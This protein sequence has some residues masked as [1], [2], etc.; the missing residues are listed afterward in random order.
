MA[1]NYPINLHQSDTDNVGD[2]AAAP[3]LYFGLNC[4]RGSV[5]RPP[6]SLRGRHV[7]IGGGGL[8]HRT[9]D[10]AIRRII[11]TQ[12]AVLIAWGIGA[13][14]HGEAVLAYPDWL[15]DFNFVGCRDWGSPFDWVPCAS[16]MSPLFDRA[17]AP[18]HRL[19]IYEHHAAKLLPD[20]DAPRLKNV[21]VSMAK[22]VSHLASGE[23]VATNSYHGAYWGILLGRRVVVYPFSNRHRHFRHMP[24]IAR[25]GERPLDAAERCA[26]HKDALTVCREANMQFCDRVR[27]YLAR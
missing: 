10:T 3:S 14:T 6:E 18:K 12:P 25:P 26:E 7:I 2:L 21:K 5:L 16:C 15:Y 8:T 24:A 27:D 19:V 13:N 11:A 17:P 9:F 20:I 4:R 23:V 22:A 1:L